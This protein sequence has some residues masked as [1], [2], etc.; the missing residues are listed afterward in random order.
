M[1]R[2][3]CRIRNAKQ[4]VVLCSHGERFKCGADMNKIEIIE[5]GSLIIGEDGKII[6]VGT[7]E[8]LLRDSRFNSNDATFDQDIDATNQ[9]VVPGL[10]DAHTHPVW[11][12]DRTHEFAMKLAG[13]QY[14]DIHKMGGG[15]GFSV[16]HTRAAS[17]QQLEQLFEQRL[18][19]MVRTGTT[20][21]EAKSGYGLDTT[22]EMKMLRVIHNVKNRYPWA[23]IVGTF[24]VHSI[25][26]EKKGN[27]HEYVEEVLRDQ[28]P[29]LSQLKNE[30]VISPDFV[31]VFHENGVFHTEDA[32][33]ILQAGKDAGFLLNFHGD[34][35]S[36]MKSAELAA[37]LGAVAVS[38]LERVSDDGI[39]QMAEKN[40][41][42][43]LLPTTAYVLGIAYPPAR[44]LISSN[45]PV[46]IASDFNP[47]AHCLSMPFVM[48]LSCVNMKMT[49]NEALVAATLNAAAS[50]NRS[51]MYGSLEVGKMGD[52]VIIDAPIWEHL[53]YEIVDPP[54]SHVVH[55]GRI[56]RL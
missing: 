47:N 16:R 41:C 27:P 56:V 11:T 42:A 39:R 54:I 24:L 53:V 22:T 14:M 18:N 21:V 7:D 34:E 49:M 1:V 28:F 5:N 9:C 44:K 38:H 17:E 36:P 46:A 45:V 20:L 12:G 23:D 33:R 35:L 48:N 43:I 26:A 32:R 37:E 2:Y 10:V 8:E 13:A 15:I 4:L 51:S 6:A 40:I 25:P 3:L 55:H 29:A 30:G 19:R 50:L 52:C 31:D